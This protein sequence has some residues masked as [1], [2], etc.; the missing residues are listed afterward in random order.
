MSVFDSVCGSMCVRCDS[1][2]VGVYELCVWFLRVC[3][4]CVLAYV[5]ILHHTTTQVPVRIDGEEAR[6][7]LDV[8]RDAPDVCLLVCVL[9]R[10]SVRC[11]SVLVCVSVCKCV[12]V[13]V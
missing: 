12:S 7:V 4:M 9:V 5:H 10:A 8:L 6:V 13:L 2:W 11:V 1:G 3:F